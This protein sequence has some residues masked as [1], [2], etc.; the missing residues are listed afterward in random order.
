MRNKKL[1]FKIL[2]FTLLLFIIG[3]KN[4]EGNSNSDKVLQGQKIVETGEL[5]AVNSRSFVMPRYGRNWYR[6]KIVGILKHGTEV[7]V[8]DS[9]FQLDDTEIKKYIIDRESQLETQLAVYQKLLVNQSNKKNDLESNVKNEEASFDLKKLELESAKFESEKAK[10]IKQLE[11]EQAKISLGKVKKEVTLYEVI[12]ENERKI[13]RIQTKQLQNE[14]KK[15]YEILPALT[16]RTPISGIFQVGTNR[17][18]R[19]M[20]KIGDEIYQGNLLGN[21]PDLKW[22]KVNSTVSEN[23]F[24]RLKVGQKVIVRLDALPKVAFNGKISYIGKL[25]HTIDDKSRKKV[26]DVEV[27]ILK[28]DE[29]LKPGMTV[30]CEYIEKN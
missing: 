25:C 14:I 7:N 1:R 13:E 15:A 16:I 21:V 11:F 10:R 20:V 30:S 29:R 19:E 28:P 17:R 22:M 9:I 8:G 6:M 3:C 27:N 12:A 4:N 18:T 2:V 26:F 23:D 5:A 24:L